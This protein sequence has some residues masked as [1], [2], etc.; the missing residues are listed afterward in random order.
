MSPED[1][2]LFWH[3]STTPSSIADVVERSLN[4]GPGVMAQFCWARRRLKRSWPSDSNTY[5]ASGLGL[6]SRQRH[7]GTREVKCGN[8]ASVARYQ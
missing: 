1:G 3:D 8:G 6:E 5:D 2:E 7:G 4:G